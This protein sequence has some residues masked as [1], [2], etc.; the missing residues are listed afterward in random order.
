MLCS[1]DDIYDYTICCAMMVW[2]VFK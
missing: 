2:F 1:D